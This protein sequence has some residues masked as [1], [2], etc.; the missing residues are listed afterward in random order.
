M[1]MVDKQ[2]RLTWMIALLIIHAERM[3]YKLT[4]GDAYRAQNVP[5]GH[6]NSLHSKR[7]AVDFNLFKLISFL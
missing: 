3:G 6:E 4:F 2:A 7:L 5:Y 1:G